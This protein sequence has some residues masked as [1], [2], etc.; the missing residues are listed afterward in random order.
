M[1]HVLSKGCAGPEVKTVQRIIYARGIDRTLA[2]DG[3][4]G[5]KTKAGVLALQKQLGIEQDGVVG[6]L[7]WEH[8]LGHL[9]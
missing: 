6:R 7:T 1:L 5:P 4:F 9:A 2:V 3:E 8:V